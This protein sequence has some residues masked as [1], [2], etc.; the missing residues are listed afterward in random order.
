MIDLKSYHSSIVVDET[1]PREVHFGSD[2]VFC[3][4]DIS[5]EEPAFIAAKSMIEAQCKIENGRF[6]GDW[7][8]DL[9]RGM[10][11]DRDADGTLDAAFRRVVL[12]ESA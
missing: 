5:D 11:R 4:R 9:A 1:G 12:R 3:V 10:V 8:D 7:I 2:F 6:G